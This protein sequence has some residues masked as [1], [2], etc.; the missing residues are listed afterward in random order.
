ML[1]LSTAAAEGCTC[2]YESPAEAFDRATA[3]FVG[4]VVSAKPESPKYAEEGQTAVTLVEESFKGARV[5]GEVA[6]IQPGDTCTPTFRAGARQLF[7]ANYVRKTKTWTVYGCTRGSNLEGAADDLLYLRA[8]PLSAE[9]NRVSGTIRH[10]EDGP[11]K[12]PT[13]VG[14]LAGLKVRIKGKDK[15]YEVTTELERRL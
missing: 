2:G 9:R 13:T 7:Y 3:V 14:R 5:G 15:T 10:Y 4:R 1:L 11:D 6:F 8:L 12:G